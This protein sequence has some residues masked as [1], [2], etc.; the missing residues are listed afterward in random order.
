MK[1]RFAVPVT[2]AAAWAFFAVM[3][4][5]APAEAQR[6][7]EHPA[8]RQDNVNANHGR[9]PE[10]PAHRDAHAKPE[11]DR[12]PGGR[13]N[14]VPHVHE[15]HWYGHDRPNDK[16]Y[17]IVHPYPH[18]RFE[19]FGPSYRYHVDRFDLG[20][21]RFWFPGGFSFEIASW[22]WDLASSWCWDCPGDNLVVYDDPDHPGW[23]LVYNAQTGVY[24]H[25]Q[26]LGS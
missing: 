20:A 25:A 1:I 23:Y 22:D 15:D 7:G 3:S 11:I 16:R 2:L 4:I 12:R 18:G 8:E 21:H 14:S 13:V 10:A 26:Y 17:V 6:P 24:V 5:G 9:I 19:H